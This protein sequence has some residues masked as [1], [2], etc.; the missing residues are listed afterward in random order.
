EHVR[1]RQHG[2]EQ[3]FVLGFAEIEHDRLLAAIEPD[4]IGA[5]A[6]D[7]MIV[8]A[9]EIALGSFD[10]DHAR[11]GVSKTAGALRRC[12]GLL[13][14]NKGKTGEWEGHVTGRSGYW[15]YD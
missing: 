12:H 6:V 14:R 15:G 4:E 10:L 3:S 9:C 11:T 5:L 1:L 2:F 13:K 7:D 8:V